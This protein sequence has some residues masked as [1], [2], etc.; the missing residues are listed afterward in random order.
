MAA[1]EVNKLQNWSDILSGNKL[2]YVRK[3]NYYCLII[4]DWEGWLSWCAFSQIAG[5]GRLFYLCTLDVLA[6]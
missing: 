5:W 4:F 6:S 1:E 2:Q 3:W